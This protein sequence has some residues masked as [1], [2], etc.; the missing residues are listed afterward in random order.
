VRHYGGQVN[1][2]QVVLVVDD[3]HLVM[4]TVMALLENDRGLHVMGASS[5][6]SA[7]AHLADVG[8]I[9]ILVSDYRLWRARSGLELCELA[10]ALNDGIAIVLISA[11]PEAEVSVRP[12]RAVYLQ[13]P[14]GRRDLLRAVKEAVVKVH[15]VRNGVG[16]CC[17]ERGAVAHL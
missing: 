14:F 12:R 4:E 7:A 9:D 6:D 10:V 8:S 3:E 5:F 15:E 17:S 2:K 1:T 13:K 11:E 16:T